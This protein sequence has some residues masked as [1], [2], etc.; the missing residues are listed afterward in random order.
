MN[1]VYKIKFENLD[2]KDYLLLHAEILKTLNELCYS[3][4]CNVVMDDGRLEV[5]K[6]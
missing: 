6:H 4:N 2:P 3:Y 1:Q 5:E